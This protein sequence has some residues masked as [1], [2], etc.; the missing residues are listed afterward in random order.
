MIVNRNLLKIVFKIASTELS[1]SAILCSVVM[2]RI[3]AMILPVSNFEKID[4]EI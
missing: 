1:A 4:D 3:T 2:S